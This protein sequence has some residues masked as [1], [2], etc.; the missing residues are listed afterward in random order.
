MILRPLLLILVLLAAPAALAQPPGP[1]RWA[2]TSEAQAALSSGRV[3]S[4]T[5]VR[6]ALARIAALDHAGPKLNAVI[7]LNPHALEDARALDRER[8]AGRVRGPLHGVPILLKDN[9]ETNDGTATTA[10]SL[11]LAG[12]V[13]R[14]DAPLAKRLKDAG[15][16][17][18]GKANL[19]EWAN[20]RGDNSISGWSAVGGIVRNP[21]ALDRSPCGSSSGS[22][23]AVAAGYV[24]L[25]IGTETDGSITCPAAANGVVG[26]KP[27]V[28][29][30]SRTFIV[31]IS[32]EQDTAGPIARTVHDAAAVL[33][34][35]AGTDPADPATREADARKVDYLAALKPDGLRGVRIGVLRGS[36]SS[37]PATQA[38]FDKALA[39]LRDAGAVL[40]EVKSPERPLL[41]PIFVGEDAGLKAEF[42]VA[43]DAYLASTPASQPI[44]TLEQLIAFNARTPAELALFGQEVFEQSAKAPPLTDA[45]YLEQ[46]G[47]AR[48]LSRQ[49]LEGMLTSNNVEVLVAASGGP[50]FL[51]DP[52]NG[53]SFTG[54]AAGLP[55]VAGAPHLTVPMGQVSGLP[56]GI[57]FIGRAWDDAKVL[58]AG[59]AFEQATRAWRAPTFLPS[60]SARPETTRVFDPHPPA[61][62][63]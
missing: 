28:G 27:T 9:I 3:T 57:S 44:R 35:I 48:R 63:R 43:I 33:A 36:A 8:K 40:V 1:G 17:V 37:S 41:T 61:P 7:A 22:A 54:G 13:T 6:E 23:V 60:I 20:F 55:A 18:L 53:D 21:H 59:Y 24:A 25:A 56:V 52:V 42:K 26:F 45:K 46:R 4:E 15:A 32:P 62:R 19:S 38:V 2:S 51:I 16:V 14:R 12:N 50:A 58:A 11:A 5:L 39:T 10:G 47:A 29:L 31:P 30:V 49:F 34:A